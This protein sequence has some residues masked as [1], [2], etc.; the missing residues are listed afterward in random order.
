MATSWRA[1]PSCGEGGIRAVVWAVS[2]SGDCPA[3]TFYEALDEREKAKARAL[4]DYLSDNQTL[5]NTEKF[6]KLKGSE[7]WELKTTN[8]R[9]TC[10]FDRT[11]RL[12]VVDGFKK[13]RQKAPAAEIDRAEDVRKK[14]QP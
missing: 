6:R 2:D 1:G 11:N 10:F 14:Y 7:V 9:F 12:V 3:R 8:S 5:T 13:Q 4:F